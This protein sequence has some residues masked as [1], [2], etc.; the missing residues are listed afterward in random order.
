MLLKAFR[1]E[2]VSRR[3]FNSIYLTFSLLRNMLLNKFL[4]KS[5]SH[6]NINKKV[7]IYIML[8]YPCSSG[9]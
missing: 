6:N 9:S 8:T 7:P 5:S 2:F 3:K 1:W 4:Y